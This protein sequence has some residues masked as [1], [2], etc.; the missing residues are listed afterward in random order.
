M[1]KLLSDEIAAVGSS[2]LESV[3]CWSQL[4]L[5]L[6]L[7]FQEFCK[8]VVWETQPLLEIISTYNQMNYYN[9]NKVRNSQNFTSCFVIFYYNYCTLRYTYIYCIRIYYIMKHYWS[10]LLINSWF[11]DIILAACYWSWGR[12]FIPWKWAKTTNHIITNQGALPSLVSELLNTYWL[13]WIK[14]GGHGSSRI[15]I[16]S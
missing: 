2:M 15:P 12:K 13:S 16:A 14:I 3:M 11:S 5:A 8:L 9:I 1:P 10:S 7:N 4:T 6:L